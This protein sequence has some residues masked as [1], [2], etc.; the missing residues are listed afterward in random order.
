MIRV[1]LHIGEVYDALAIHEGNVLVHD[2]RKDKVKFLDKREV[3]E[4]YGGSS[5]Q[6]PT[7][8]VKPYKLEKV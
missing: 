8:D 3:L 2:K 4:W 1:R 5:K 7:L 6:L